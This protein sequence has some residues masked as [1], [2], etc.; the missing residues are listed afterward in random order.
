M[1]VLTI[2]QW[3]PLSY[4]RETMQSLGLHH[5]WA[6]P[7]K[8][9]AVHRCAWVGTQIEA[10]TCNVICPLLSANNSDSAIKLQKKKFKWQQWIWVPRWDIDRKITSNLETKSQALT[11]QWLQSR[12][13]PV[14]T[15]HG[16]GKM[17]FT[18]KS[19]QVLAIWSRKLQNYKFQDKRW[20]Q[21][22]RR[23]AKFNYD[24]LCTLQCIDAS[25]IRQHIFLVSTAL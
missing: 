6:N 1:V 17:I 11:R 3:W 21:H 22:W 2:Q 24:Q 10:K 18:A 7:M 5:G 13:R 19:C 4:N 16:H 8:K 20:R 23:V 9:L 15:W 25:N 14:R 12:V